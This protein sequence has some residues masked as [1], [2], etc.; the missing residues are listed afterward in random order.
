MRGD[1]DHPVIAANNVATLDAAAIRFSQSNVRSSLPEI[2]AGMKANGWQGAPIDVV[3]MADGT[4]T[5]VDNPRL[6]AAA[7]S[8]TPVQAT[9][10]GFPSS[11]CWRE[12]PRWNVG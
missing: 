1:F 2:T 3:R 10:R 8:N 4:L 9:I 7:L 6:A 12:P 11:P 5:A